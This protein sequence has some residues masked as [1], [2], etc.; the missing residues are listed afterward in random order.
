MFK[1]D[2]IWLTTNI[3]VMT[4]SHQSTSFIL[5][6]YGE[7][8]ASSMQRVSFLQLDCAPRAKDLW[9]SLHPSQVASQ[10]RHS[11]VV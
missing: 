6:I 2:A 4:L 9:P 3:M 11:L 5:N 8:E 1:T 7:A 10:I